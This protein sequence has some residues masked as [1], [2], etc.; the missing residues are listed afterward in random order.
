M[1]I[2]QAYVTAWS[3]R[4]CHFH[5]TL[6]HLSDH[7]VSVGTPVPNTQCLRC[8]HSPQGPA[9]LPGHLGSKFPHHW[10]PETVVPFSALGSLFH[11]SVAFLPNL[12]NCFRPSQVPRRQLCSSNSV[13]RHC[14]PSMAKKQRSENCRR[15]GKKRRKRKKIQ[16]E[17]PSLSFLAA[18]NT[19][20]LPKISTNDHKII[21]IVTYFASSAYF[22]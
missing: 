16:K 17:K 10:N 9:I 11:F 3:L 15:W 4:F 19:N 8:F 14:K 22:K 21:W 20:K 1:S 7:R 18:K 12:S 5:V 2:V 13:S 6:G